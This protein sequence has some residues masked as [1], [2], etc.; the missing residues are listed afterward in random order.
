MALISVSM[1]DWSADG[2]WLAFLDGFGTISLLPAACLADPPTCAGQIE[3]V[4]PTMPPFW[5]TLSPDGERLL[6]FANGARDSRSQIYL[7][8]RRTE[9]TTRLTPRREEA[10]VMDWSADERYIAYSAGFRD[11][12]VIAV[13]D[14][15]RS[16]RL[17]VLRGDGWHLYPSWGVPQSE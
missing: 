2:R 9:T 4:T 11:D 1:P 17:R 16:I 5:V 6:Y 10:A 7:Y 3:Q 13:L 12:L 15:T 14:M 8:D